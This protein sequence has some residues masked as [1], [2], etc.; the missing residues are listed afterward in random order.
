MFAALALTI[1]ASSAAL[2]AHA[3]PD[4]TNPGPGDVFIEGQACSMSWNPDTTGVWK[5]MI[6]QLKTGDNFNMVNLTTVGTVDGTDATK[7]SFSYPCPQVT[8]HSPIYFYQFSSPASTNS[9]WTGRFTITD[10][11]TDIVPAAE[12]TQ[13]DGS[14]IPW[15]TGSLVNSTSTTTVVITGSTSATVS[16]LG[17]SSATSSVSNASNNASLTG[18][19]TD[20]PSSII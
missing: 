15:G 1:L 18:S 20:L 2:F 16:T 14:A 13:S 4:P 12:S 9:V 7:T 6:I 5:T 3:D 11:V 10:S 8:P 19:R 17:T